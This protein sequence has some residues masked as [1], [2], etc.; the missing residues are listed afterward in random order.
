[1]RNMTFGF[2]IATL[3]LA[4]CNQVSGVETQTAATAGEIEALRSRIGELEV[5]VRRLAVEQ[6]RVI[7][8]LRDITASDVNS[9]RQWD[10]DIKR[11]S[12]NDRAFQAQIDYLRALQ[13]KL[14]MP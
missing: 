12:D 2:L 7:T 4:G 5:E 8:T 9:G 13:G 6:S 10:S 14:P 11:L 1:M 3:M